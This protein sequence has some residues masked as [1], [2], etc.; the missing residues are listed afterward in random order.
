MKRKIVV[1]GGAGFIGS[2]LVRALVA[3]GHRV[4]VV[5]NLVAGKAEHVHREAELCVRDIRDIASFRSAFVRADTVFHLAALPRVQLSI[6]KPLETGAVNVNGTMNVLVAAQDAGVRRVVFASSSSVYGDHPALPKVEDVVG[7]PLS[8]YAVSKMADEMYAH[9]FGRCYPLELLGLRYFNVFG[10]RQDPD[11]AYAAVVPLWFSGL[12]RGRP[13]AIN[14]DG[15]TS[16]DFCYVANV[17]QANL[18]AATVD[19]PDA[20]NQAYNVAVGARST[21]DELFV[22]LRD[23]LVSRHPHLAGSAPTYGPPRPG[24]V[25]HSLADI[26]KACRLLGYQP[27]HSIEQGLDESLSWYETH[28]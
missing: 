21:L 25:M 10:P 26:S 22:L 2:H 15:E 6:Q 24:D 11:G 20:L 28:L 19:R 17:V 18:L 16:R 7:R 8:P 23:R 3:L 14:G 9:V 27:T 1:T 13:I 12:L 5:D 4:V